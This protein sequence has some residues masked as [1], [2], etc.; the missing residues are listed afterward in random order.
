MS[1]RSSKLHGSLQDLR[2]ELRQLEDQRREAVANRWPTDRVDYDIHQ[3]KLDIQEAKVEL[4]LEE[5]YG[6]REEFEEDKQI[7]RVV[8]E[9]EAQRAWE[10]YQAALKRWVKNGAHPPKPAIIEKL[11][12]RWLRL[13]QARSHQ[14]KRGERRPRPPG[15][16]RLRVPRLNV[17]RGSGGPKGRRSSSRIHSTAVRNS[18]WVPPPKETYSGGAGSRVRNEPRPM[19]I[20]RGRL[21]EQETQQA[22]PG[23]GG[24]IRIE[25]NGLIE[26]GY[27]SFKIPFS[28]VC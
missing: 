9:E 24:I 2:E 11:E 10:E 23:E 18:N 22:P 14:R 4:E 1:D 13:S 7:E 3:L 5:R 27:R 21:R 8:S 16:N 28:I 15:R 26:V 19:R 25:G 12:Q 20:R 6:G 17:R